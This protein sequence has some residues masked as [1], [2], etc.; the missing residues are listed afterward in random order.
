MGEEELKDVSSK[1]SSQR[2][3]TSTPVER[4]P[5][6]VTGSEPM[7]VDTQGLPSTSQG[8]G[9]SAAVRPKEKGASASHTQSQ[10]IG[11]RKHV[12][13]KAK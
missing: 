3:R 11:Q 4:A 8:S 1:G 10:P 6:Q 9:A 5:P 2:P 7:E 13:Q 12:D